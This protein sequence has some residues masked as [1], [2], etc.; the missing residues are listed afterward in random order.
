MDAL[1]DRY[2]SKLRYSAKSFP[3]QVGQVL[4]HVPHEFGVKI[5]HMVF[6]D[7]DHKLGGHVTR[8]SVRG[9]DAEDQSFSGELFEAHLGFFWRKTDP[10]GDGAC[11]FELQGHFQR[12]LGFIRREKPLENAQFH[13][14]FS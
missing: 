5:V 2:G 6:P 9:F 12:Q 1:A 4:V 8:L 10:F 14:A 7:A 13:A 11:R 3:A